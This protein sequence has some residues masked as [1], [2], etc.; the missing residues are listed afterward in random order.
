MCHAQG[1]A[2][3]GPTVGAT[4]SASI[5]GLGSKQTRTGSSNACR[6]FTMKARPPHPGGRLGRAQRGDE[7]ATYS[8]GSRAAARGRRRCYRHQAG[9]Q[10][11]W[12]LEGSNTA[13][14]VASLPSPRRASALPAGRVPHRPPLW[15]ARQAPCVAPSSS[16]C[17]GSDTGEESEGSSRPHVRSVAAMVA[18]TLERA[19]RPTERAHYGPDTGRGHHHEPASRPSC[20]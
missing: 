4:D 1:S 3:H 6:R 15:A 19:C 11:P 5:A 13:T 20:R 14:S 7:S 12:L 10:P 2:E 18:I 9:R 8:S 17:G 16:T